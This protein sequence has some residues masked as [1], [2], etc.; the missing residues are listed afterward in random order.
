MEVWKF[1][2]NGQKI[3]K[4]KEKKLSSIRK[5][6]NLLSFS[7]IFFFRIKIKKNHWSE[8]GM[9]YFPKNDINV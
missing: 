1:N 3:L 8:N 5:V 7:Q 4:N 2:I 6:S 9:E